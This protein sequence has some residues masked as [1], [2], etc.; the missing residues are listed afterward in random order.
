MVRED[1]LIQA[2]ERIDPDRTGQAAVEPELFGDLA[3]DRDLGMLAAL[4]EARDEAVPTGRSANAV[5]ENDAV[6]A[7]DDCGDDGHGIAPMHEAALRAGEA[8]LPAA[9]DCRELG[10]A[11]RA[12]AIIR[13]RH[14]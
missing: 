13:V 11:V 10:A 9:L 6:R 4:E 1:H 3:Q 5:H 7:L 14:D 2:L 12:I 8:R